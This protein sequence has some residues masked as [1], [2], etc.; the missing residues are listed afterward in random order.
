M[1]GN[2]VKR[3]ARISDSIVGY[4]TLITALLP[5]N[6]RLFYLSSE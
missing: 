5:R 4:R 2:I 6:R 3:S 1:V